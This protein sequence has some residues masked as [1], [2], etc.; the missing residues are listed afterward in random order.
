MRKICLLVLIIA[1]LYSACKKEA[2]KN[3]AISKDSVISVDKDSSKLVFKLPDTVLSN[4]NASFTAWFSYKTQHHNAYTYTITADYVEPSNFVT[5]TTK[6][7]NG[8]VASRDYSAYDYIIDTIH[9]TFTRDTTAKW[10]EQGN[11]LNTH[12]EAGQP[13]TLDDIY[14]KAKTVW[15]NVDPSKNTIYFETKNAG[16]I[17]QCGS[18][19]NGCQDNCFLGIQ[20]ISSITTP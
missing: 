5:I 9:N 1:G 6:V 2:T 7:Q 16:L 19:L 8:L 4:Y 10:H 3:A 13:M 18:F 15:L 20:N 12:T 17:S 14:L 11:T